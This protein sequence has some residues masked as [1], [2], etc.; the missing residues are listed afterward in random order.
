MRRR[1]TLAGLGSAQRGTAALETAI[2]F[3]V[4]L[5]LLTCLFEFGTYLFASAN[6]EAAVREAARYGATGA[7]VSGVSREERILEIVEDRTLGMLKAGD[8]GVSM[9]VYPSFAAI[10]A[11]A[12]TP[13]VGGPGDVVLYKFD[14]TWSAITPIL[15]PL[16]DGVV[17]SASVAFRNEEF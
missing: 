7:E 11:E 4:F 2:L 8:A 3:P 1:R 9:R 13:G 16:L 12:G 17:L 14:Y 15:E 10:G 5:L 6:L